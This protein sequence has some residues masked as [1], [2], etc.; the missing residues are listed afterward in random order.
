MFS[1][2]VN[3]THLTFT[4]VPTVASVVPSC[5]RLRAMSLSERT[6]LGS[7]DLTNPEG[8]IFWAPGIA[9]RHMGLKDGEDDR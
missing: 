9:C 3:H 6:E 2:I 4:S 7:Q 1:R 5:V 8:P